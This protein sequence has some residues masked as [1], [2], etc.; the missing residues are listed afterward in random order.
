MRRLCRAVPWRLLLI[1]VTL[2]NLV[3]DLRHHYDDPARWAVFLAVCAAVLVA[4]LVVERML[5][6]RRGPTSY[7]HDP[8][9]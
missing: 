6:I 4:I 7:N 2:G 5:Q 3:T 1:L 8:P 9:R